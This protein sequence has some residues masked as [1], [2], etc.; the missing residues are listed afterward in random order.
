M[1]RFAEWYNVCSENAVNEHVSKMVHSILRM[2]TTM[3][4]AGE[5]TVKR[6]FLNKK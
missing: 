6:I 5:I 1:Q 2:D 3:L 4:T